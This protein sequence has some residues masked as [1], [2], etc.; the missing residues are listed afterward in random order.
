MAIFIY[1][2]A[3]Q[4]FKYSIVI[5][6]YCLHNGLLLCTIPLWRLSEKMPIKIYSFNSHWSSDA[7]WQLG[8]GSTLAQIM[9]CC[10]M[11]PSHYL[12]QCWF[13]IG[14]VL[15]HSPESY[16]TVGTQETILWWVSK[17]YFQ[18]Y[19]HISH[20]PTSE[21]TYFF[22][23][24]ACLIHGS[25]QLVPSN[26][27]VRFMETNAQYVAAIS[28]TT[29]WNAFSWMKMY[30]VRLQFH[31]SLFLRFEITILQHWFRWWLG[32]DLAPSHNLNQ[33]W[34][35]YWCIYASLG[36][37]E[38]RMHRKA[39][40]VLIDFCHLNKM[41]NILC[42]EFSNAFLSIK[43]CLSIQI[44]SFFPMRFSCKS[45]WLYIIFSGHKYCQCI[46]AWFQTMWINPR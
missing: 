20:G 18:D 3:C 39:S 37:N 8:S 17:L 34:L 11:A 13:L 22:V 42:K 6:A 45:A 4:V 24:D 29:F 27:L 32:A 30:E 35:I 38:L 25:F 19:C 46:H 40:M 41:A 15:L 5:M 14:E 43:F 12:N 31:W 23:S 10:L 44:S 21:Q 9:A 16:C 33:W 28:Q 36:L 2:V 7:I 26:S 1:N